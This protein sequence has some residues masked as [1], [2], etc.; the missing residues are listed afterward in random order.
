MSFQRLD[1]D[2]FW[3]STCHLI[4]EYC[5]YNLYSYLYQLSESEQYFVYINFHLPSIGWSICKS[6]LV[7][8]TSSNK[9]SYFKRDLRTFKSLWHFSFFIIRTLSWM[10]SSKNVAKPS[11]IQASVQ[12]WEP[13][14]IPNQAWLTSWDILIYWLLSP[15]NKLEVKIND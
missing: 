10:N 1:L 15:E 14:M 9:L 3:Q 2:H 7:F 4:Q 12:S 8:E 11:E 5:L 6:H 13:M